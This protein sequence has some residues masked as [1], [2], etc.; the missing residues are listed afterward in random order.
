[1]VYV[2]QVKTNISAVLVNCSSLSHI[3]PPPHPPTH[4]INFL[5]HSCGHLFLYHHPPHA[6]TRFGNR[7]PPHL[8]ICSPSDPHSKL[9]FSTHTQNHTHAPPHIPTLHTSQPPTLS[10]R[11]VILHV[12]FLLGLFVCYLLLQH[13]SRLFPQTTLKKGFRQSVCCWCV[14]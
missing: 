11:L 6:H 13:N 9:V 1:M 12:V 7:P 2:S 10:Q 14:S 3:P 4:T 5:I 8:L